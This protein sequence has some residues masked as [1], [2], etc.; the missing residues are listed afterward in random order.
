MATLEPTLASQTKARPK[1]VYRVIVRVQ[2]E[3]DERQAQLES[4]GFTVSRKLKLI[5]GF[6]ASAPGTCIKRAQRNDWI[7][8]IEPDAQVRTMENDK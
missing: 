3:L 7:I 2:G 5:R 1:E 8:S 6:S 4:L